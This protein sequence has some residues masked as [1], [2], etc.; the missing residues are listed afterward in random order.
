MRLLWYAKGT[1]EMRLIP[2]I[3]KRLCLRG[4]FVGDDIRAVVPQ[5]L[6]VIALVLL[7]AMHLAQFN[8]GHRAAESLDSAAR[9]GFPDCVLAD[10]AS[11]RAA[12]ADWPFSRALLCRRG[13]TLPL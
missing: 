6:N 13:Q 1:H 12:L 5:I 7:L 8:A 4:D 9:A 11:R 10:E 2:Q 3:A